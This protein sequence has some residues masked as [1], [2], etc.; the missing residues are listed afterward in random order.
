[1]HRAATPATL[2]SEVLGYLLSRRDG[3]FAFD[4]LRDLAG[5]PDRPDTSGAEEQLVTRDDPVAD[6]AVAAYG[7]SAAAVRVVWGR[8]PSPQHSAA[9]LANQ[10]VDANG[11][12]GTVLSYAEAAAL[13]SDG[14]AALMEALFSNPKLRPDALEEVFAGRGPA[15]GLN[16]AAWPAVFAGLAKNPSIGDLFDTRRVFPS[17]AEREHMHGAL[18]S[19]LATLPAEEPVA[20]P[21]A[22]MLSALN[23]HRAPATWFEASDL[24]SLMLHWHPNVQCDATSHGCYRVVMF[25]AILCTAYPEGYERHPFAAVRAARMALA[26]ISERSD[27]QRLAEADQASFFAGM[28]YNACLYERQELGLAFLELAAY[29]NE[30][31]VSIYL[32]RRRMIDQLTG[33]DLPLVRRDLDRLHEIIEMR[34]DMTSAGQPISEDLLQAMQERWSKETVSGMHSAPRTFWRRWRFH[35][36]VALLIA[37]LLLNIREYWIIH[38][39][40]IPIPK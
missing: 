17:A 16:P 5:N 7:Q 19:R 33:A 34:S 25:L 20:T 38:P 37:L 11:W 27:L 13:L 15:Q 2:T 3:G 40:A 9:V 24:D 4:A 1:M 10:V 8:A 22:C 35:I 12:G 31:A 28:P 21:L 36:I 30:S 6:L 18:F 23:D 39:G 14:D 29:R 26:N 32:A